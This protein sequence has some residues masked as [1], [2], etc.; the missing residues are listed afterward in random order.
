MHCSPKSAGCGC[1][2]HLKPYSFGGLILKPLSYS[3]GCAQMNQ[4]SLYR[5]ENMLVAVFCFGLLAG[6]LASSVSVHGY[7][8]CKTTVVM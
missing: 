7:L 4:V 3:A 5:R 6:C 8:C 1:F 2:T